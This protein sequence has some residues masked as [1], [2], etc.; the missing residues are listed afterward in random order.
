MVAVDQ[1]D[2][3]IAK[4]LDAIR[5]GIGIREV[6]AGCGGDA[7]AVVTRGAPSILENRVEFIGK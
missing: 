2:Q 7:V 3:R 4:S 1:S 6:Q 5:G